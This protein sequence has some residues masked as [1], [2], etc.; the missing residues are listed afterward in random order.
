M[1]KK[2]S[3]K[4]YASSLNAEA[5]SNNMQWTR[6]SNQKG[7]HGFTA[8]DW[9]K[10]LE[11]IC[12]NKVELVGAN[13]AKNGPDL[14][15]NGVGH[16][17]KYH[18][19][20]WETLESC[21]D[22]TGVFRYQGQKVTVPSD[23]YDKV[24]ELMQ[25]KI[26]SGKVPGVSDPS[27]A[28]QIVCKG[29]VSYQTALRSVKAGTP[30]SIAF[31]VLSQAKGAGIMSSIIFAVEAIH[32][33][34]NGASAKEATKQAAKDAGEMGGKMLV[35]GVLSQQL[36]RTQCGRDIVATVTRQLRRMGL[37]N[38][39]TKLVRSNVVASGV[40][41]AVDTVPDAI[42]ACRGK[43]SWGEFGKNRAVSA[44]GIAGGSGGYIAGAAIGTAICPGV[45][46]AIGGFIGG[47]AAGMASSASVQKIF[48]CFK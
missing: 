27:A 4:G 7:G 16:Q 35:A 18:K 48:D 41:F 47:I 6:F 36:L 28:K 23:Q 21:F 40:F 22:E 29:R 8:E 19:S 34:W 32:L 9:N 17:L 10:L 39:G 31:D 37:S 45:G 25:Q 38:V 24:L 42:R 44:A 2:N 1:N 46:T 20:A 43:I 11:K 33:M 26:A 14:L 3:V 13:N 30:E 12:G 15:I 5:T